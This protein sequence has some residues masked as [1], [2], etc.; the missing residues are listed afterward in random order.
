MVQED[1]T[2]K[3]RTI[4]VTRP[5][6][7]AEETGR[8][9][10]EKGGKPY[11]FPTI[12]IKSSGASPDIKRFF[13]ALARGAVDYVVFMSV[14]GVEHLLKAAENL[15]LG[16]QLEKQIGKA[17]I[18]A[19]GPKTAQEL[20]K[21]RIRVDLV[22]PTYTSDGIIE[23]LR[24]LGVSGKSIW[25][26]RTKQASQVMAEKLR[27]MGNTAHEVYVYESQPPADPELA[28]QFLQDLAGG[29]IHA[30]VFSSALGARNLF[31]MLAAHITAEKLRRLLN[32]VTI[33]AI[34]P[35]TAEAL[36]DIGWKVDVM[37]KTYLFEEALNA[38]AHYWNVNE[39]IEVSRR[40]KET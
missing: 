12:E 20:E 18:V 26:P 2:L 27:A 10:V 4:V 31:R 16:N 1:R 6:E 15:G 32:K 25:I 33:V 38:L 29:R 17:K 5:R 19:V 40:Q 37:P 3:G 36:S 8:L 24:Q 35:K 13:D 39:R 30:I 28:L 7:Q 34:G 23:S 9:I 21:H 11:F 22:P 14:N